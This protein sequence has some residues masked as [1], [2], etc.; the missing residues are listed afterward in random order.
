MIGRTALNHPEICSLISEKKPKTREE[1]IKLFINLSK[2]YNLEIKYQKNNLLQLVSGFS[3]S[4][5]LR[6]KL[7]I[8]KTQEDIEAVLY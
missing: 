4:K 2:K 1:N 7:S 5:R 3:G 6:E 8:A